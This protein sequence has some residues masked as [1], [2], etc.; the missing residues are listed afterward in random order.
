MSEMSDTPADD[1][2]VD[3]QVELET[4]DTASA[5]LPRAVAQRLKEAVE[6]GETDATDVEI[7]GRGVVWTLK[8]DGAEYDLDPSAMWL[9]I[10]SI[11]VE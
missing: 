3:V 2:L 1:D 11:S 6:F 9:S 10:K 8:V 4:N 7:A 5:T